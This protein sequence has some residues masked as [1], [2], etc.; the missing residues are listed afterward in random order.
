MIRLRVQLVVGALTLLV[1]ALIALAFAL[2]KSEPERVPV[3]SIVPLA[4]VVRVELSSQQ[5]TI[6][7]RGSVRP[8]QEGNLACRVRGSVKQVSQALVV[9]GLVRAGDV[10]VEIEDHDYRLAL[11]RAHANRADAELALAREEREAQIARR[12]W[13]GD[14]DRG[15]DGEPDE[16]ALRKPQLASVRARV[17]AAEADLERAQLDLERTRVRAPFDA[18]VRSESV[19]VGDEVQVGQSLA[20]LYAPYPL[21]VVLPVKDSELARLPAR[22]LEALTTGA[23]PS[24]GAGSNGSGSQLAIDARLY[25]R[26]AGREYEWA[27]QIERTTGELDART[28]MLSLIVRV[29]D[30]RAVDGDGLAPALLPGMFVEARIGGLELPDAARLPRAAVRDDGRAGGR[31]WVADRDRKL[32]FREV[33]VAW[34]GAREVVV[35]SG[36]TSGESVVVSPLENPVDGMSLRLIDGDGAETSAAPRAER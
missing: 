26:F 31:V 27:G 13:S 17:A 8:L 23:V 10:L 34:R 25:G 35:S 7:T 12:E 29:D 11:E 20:E 5:L 2:N 15:R 3:E 32:R 1:G 6:E 19:A 33:E 28:R 30:V 4:E 9:G 18:R 14:G 36:L 22:V 16:L 21:E 24:A